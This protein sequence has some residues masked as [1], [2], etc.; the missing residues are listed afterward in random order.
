M[1]HFLILIQRH[2]FTNQTP[3][4]MKYT[5]LSLIT[6]ALVGFLCFGKKSPDSFLQK[7]TTANYHEVQDGDIIFQTTF[8]SQ[9][10]AIQLATK[11]PYS[12]VGIIFREKGKL[13]VYEAI[14]PVSITPL[15][16]FVKRGQ[17]H[18]HVIKRLKNADTVLTPEV[19]ARMKEYGAGFKGKNYDL[20]FEWSDERI[21]CSELVWKIYKE[22]AGVEVGELEKLSDFDLSSDIVKQK[23]AERYGDNIP[24][25]ELV[26]SPASI[27]NSAKLVTVMER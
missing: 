10:T 9:S 21:Y 25:D 14:Q 6:L 1:L 27:F 7:A 11:S 19:L 4:S 13:F 23:L 20:Y 8:S 24:I 5:I 2:T 16:S 3:F 17:N 18:H 22:A 15:K 12:H 26:V